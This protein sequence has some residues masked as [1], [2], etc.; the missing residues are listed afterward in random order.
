MS[1]T[2]LPVR[3][4]GVSLLCPGGIGAEGATGGRP[5]EVPG[6]RARA[7]IKDRKSL[8]LMRAILMA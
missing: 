3:V 7:Y 4:C 8:K 1:V 6:F 5:G 2:E